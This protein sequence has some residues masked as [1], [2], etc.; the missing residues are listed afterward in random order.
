MWLWLWIRVE[1]CIRGWSVFV[2]Q[3]MWPSD[4]IWQH[5][6]GSTLAQVKLVALRHQAIIWTNVDLL[7]SEIPISMPQWSMVPGQHCFRLWLVASLAPSHYLNQCWLIINWTRRN[8]YQW[9][10]IK[11]QF[12]SFDK[13]HLK[14]TAKR[15]DFLFRPQ[16]ALIKKLPRW[17]RA[18]MQ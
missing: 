16:C 17:L 15:Q 14:M 18:R 6:S 2:I 3:L 1:L 7:L 9:K 11:I 10:L 8:K 12:F 13:M 4:S 5:I